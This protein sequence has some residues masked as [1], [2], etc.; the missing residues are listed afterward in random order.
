MLMQPTYNYFFYFFHLLIYF[1]FSFSLSFFLVG[2]YY[3][4]FDEFYK[5]YSPYKLAES[6]TAG[7]NNY[8]R[9]DCSVINNK[10]VCTGNKNGRYLDE[11]KRKRGEENKKRNKF[12]YK[13]DE[14]VEGFTDKCIQTCKGVTID[15]INGWERG[16]GEHH[17]DCY[18]CEVKYNEW[19]DSP[20]YKKRKQE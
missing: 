8:K 16:E 10:I 17:V 18:N 1:F 5:D 6:C 4:F 7:M 2:E 20:H 3:F 11:D 12:L 13:S 9:K 19:G 14:T 15:K